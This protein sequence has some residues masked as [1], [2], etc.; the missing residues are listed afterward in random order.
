LR[1]P[2]RINNAKKRTEM[3]TNNTAIFRMARLIAPLC[4]ISYLS[5]F[6][7]CINVPDSKNSK[8][9]SVKIVKGIFCRTGTV[10]KI[11]LAYLRTYS[12]VI[13]AFNF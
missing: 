10:G 5:D 13:S 3:M 7:H 2:A 12:Q 11:S 4:P 1:H 8:F 6:N 9:E